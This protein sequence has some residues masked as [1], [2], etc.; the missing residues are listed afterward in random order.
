MNDNAA[1]VATPARQDVAFDADGT[2]LRGWFYPAAGH[3]PKPAIL[4]SHGFSALKEMSLDRYAEVFCA[5][6]FSC[7]V[8]DHRNLGASDGTPR[9]EIDPA[10]QILDM[11]H[12][13]SYL[14]QLPG[15]DPDRLGLWGSSYSGGHALVVAALDRRV[16]C[17][18]SQV[19][20]IDG[21]EAARRRMPGP[22]LDAFRKR[23][24]KDLE[25]RAKGLEPERIAVAEL[26]SGS[27]R[28]LI[29]S[30]PDA[31]HPN[32]VTLLSRELAMGYR[33]GMYIEQIAPTPLLMIVA[34][35]DE[36]TPVDLQL[37]AYERAGEPRKL[38]VLEGSSHYE[39]YIE[40]FAESSQAA[41]DWFVHHLTAAV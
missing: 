35:A 15:V 3:G 23:V 7:L 41:R 17:V 10:R 22:L 31:G 9:G 38:V 36:L 16:K 12:A 32:S 34:G 24:Y 37:A 27:M 29:D 8:Y 19:M 20:T 33:P 26:G 13:L 11:R 18:V 39:P 30:Y 21:V 14:R 6:G 28:Y 4:L 40:R 1:A 25:G 2:T 5:A